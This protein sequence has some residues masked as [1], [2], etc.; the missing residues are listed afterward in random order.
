MRKIITWIGIMAITAMFLCTLNRLAFAYSFTGA[1]TYDGL[2]GIWTYKYTPAIASGE[3]ASELSLWVLPIWN[4]TDANT[5]LEVGESYEVTVS[6]V[7]WSATVVN[8]SGGVVVDTTTYYSKVRWSTGTAVLGPYIFSDEFQLQSWAQPSTAYYDWRD[9]VG[10]IEGET[11]GPA[12]EPATVLLL[13]SGL[14]GI[15]WFA[16][17]KFRN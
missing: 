14:I 11:V 3:Y 12:A 1:A 16:R 17:R 4:A 10:G 13:G 2:T 5:T 15:G 7:G 9:G 6:P 8:Y